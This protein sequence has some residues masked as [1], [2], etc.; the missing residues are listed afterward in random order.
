[1]TQRNPTGTACVLA[2]WLAATL[3]ARAFVYETPA[4]FLVTGDF[5]TN[6]LDD[7]ALVA[8]AAGSARLGYQIAPGLLAWRAPFAVGV[9]SVAGVTVGRVLTTNRVALLCTAPAA[10]RITAFDLT[11]LAAAPVPTVIYLP[12]TNRIGPAA[13]AAVDIGGAGNTAH[14]DLL[15]FTAWNAPTNTPR[16]SG[17]RSTGTVFSAQAIDFGT[18]PAWRTLNSARASP[19]Q[20]VD[21]VLAMTRNG[22]AGVSDALRLYDCADG[23]LN[24]RLAVGGI[25]TTVAQRALWDFFPVNAPRA[26]ALVYGPGLTSFTAYRVNATASAFE[27]APTFDLG[28]PLHGLYVISTNNA[29]RLLAVYSNGLGAAVFAFDGTNPPVRAQTLSLPAGATRFTGALPLGGTNLLLCAGGAD[30][31]TTVAQ[32]HTW[33]GALYVADAATPLAGAAA[34]TANVLLFEQEPFVSF[35][36]RRV[37]ALRVGDWTTNIVFTGAS[38]RVSAAWQ[39]DAGPVTGLLAAAGS[40]ADLGAKPAAAAFAL[41]NQAHPAFSVFS[42]DPPEGAGQPEAA[43]A[44]APGVQR[45]AVEVSFS[46]WPTSAVVRYRLG[47]G[48]SWTNYNGTGGTGPFVLF[49]DTTVQYLA[50]ATNP[51]ALSRV[52]EAVYTFAEGPD[53]LDSD[54]DGVPDYVELAYGL[55]PVESGSDADGDGFDDLVELRAGTSPTNAAAVPGGD[56][57]EAA[58]SAVRADLH[59]SNYDL[60]TGGYRIFVTNVPCRAYDLRGGLLAYTGTLHVVTS[61]VT[62]SRARF[63]AVPASLHPALFAVGT[64]S[65]YRLYHATSNVWAAELAALFALPPALAPEADYA[66]AG[67]ALSAEGSNWVLAARAAWSNSLAY[68]A[69]SVDC[70]HALAGLLFERAVA[71]WMAAR[72]WTTNRT[73]TL[74]PF[75]EADAALPTPT[76]DQWRALEYRGDG[77]AGYALHAAF[78][79]LEA[80]ATNP[81]ILGDLQRLTRQVYGVAGRHAAETNT[82]FRQPIEVLRGFLAG[83][84]L[85]TN[86][87]AEVGLTP[88]QMLGASNGVG[89]ALA[90]LRA[91]PVATYRLFVRPESFDG[92]YPMLYTSNGLVKVLYADARAFFAFPDAFSLLPGTELDVTGYEDIAAPTDD[93]QGIEVISVQVVA[94]PPLAGLDSD[95]DLLTDEYETAYPAAA[96]DPYGDADGDGYSNLQ[97]MLDETDPGDPDS[98]GEAPALAEPPQVAIAHLPDGQMRVSWDWPTVYIERF[99]FVVET[100]EALAAEFAP[101]RE[102]ARG[103]DHADIVLTLGPGAEFY[104]LRLRLR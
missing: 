40:P 13:L 49:R 23:N 20:A 70:Q 91:R 96:D 57:R 101:L 10:N 88:A 38:A 100:T 56:A 25:A 27:S 80:A 93:A 98:H 85:P 24:Q 76:A 7:I 90:R 48:A 17:V 104:R 54:G 92:D 30:G 11:A 47:T 63:D 89:V 29:A 32:R 39:R 99:I 78:T 12:Q 36:P 44:P 3:G 86:Y 28:V 84:G 68:M 43:I 72:G 41:A 67:G 61:A 102:M 83:E 103:A 66:Y 94:F 95:G 81:A 79:N 33:N 59:L 46:V 65:F 8:R 5:D 18:V 4:E 2:V 50:V 15:V 51:L 74:Y 55:D 58:G 16:I 97:E 6:G 35:E 69:R 34:G 73:I 71:D 42:F 53:A 26:Q 21:W 82:A 9:E 31:I 52:D 19:T 75:R 60:P 14:A 22:G 64:P 87:Q 77:Q 37:A 62:R 45:S 1:M